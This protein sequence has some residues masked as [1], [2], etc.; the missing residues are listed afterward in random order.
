MSTTAFCEY[1]LMRVFKSRRQLH[2]LPW[3]FTAPRDV[4][5][6]VKHQK[7]PAPKNGK[8]LCPSKPTLALL[9]YQHLIS[10][11]NMQHARY[12]YRPW[13]LLPSCLFDAPIIKQTISLPRKSYLFVNDTIAHI[14]TLKNIC[15]LTAMSQVKCATTQASAW[16]A[17]KNLSSSHL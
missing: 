15:Q 17:Y 3:F 5:W 6:S 14:H 2:L 4:G 11:C 13:S 12:M 8:C 7:V 16:N 10:T 1:H 9:L